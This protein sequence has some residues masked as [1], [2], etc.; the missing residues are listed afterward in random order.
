MEDAHVTNRQDG[1]MINDAVEESPGDLHAAH[2]VYVEQ[3]LTSQHS[4]MG[5]LA[6]WVEKRIGNLFFVAEISLLPPRLPTSTEDEPQ[7][8]AK[9]ISTF[10]VPRVDEFR[11]VL[12]EAGR[13]CDESLGAR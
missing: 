11:R 1:K 9:F 6:S 12:L 8:S 7:E 5:S 10:F 3:C 2:H 13:L 4:C